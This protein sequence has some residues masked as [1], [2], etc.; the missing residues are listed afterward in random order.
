LE[1][2]ESPGSERPGELVITY[3]EEGQPEGFNFHDF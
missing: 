1:Q 2:E 3:N